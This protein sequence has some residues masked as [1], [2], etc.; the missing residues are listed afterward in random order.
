MSPLISR[1]DYCLLFSHVKIIAY[2]GREFKQKRV[3][4][5]NPYDLSARW[6]DYMPLCQEIYVPCLDNSLITYNVIVLL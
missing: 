2:L 1:A 3:K 6:A 4:A 5:L